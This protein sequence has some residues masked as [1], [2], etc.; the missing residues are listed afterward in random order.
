MKRNVFIR[1]NYFVFI[2]GLIFLNTACKK[3][4][5]STPPDVRITSIS[6]TKGSYGITDTL[7]GIGFGNNIAEVQ[8]FF[9]SVQ[10][11][12]AQIKDN[13][14]IVTV[15]KKA[16]SG[17]I[18][19]VKG[20]QKISG[21]P[22]QYINTITVT[23]LVGKGFP[24]YV[25]GKT[26]DA[27]FNF[28]RGIAM[29]AQGNIFV[30]D[31][32]NYCIRKISVDGNVTTIA[33]N[34]KKGYVDGPAANASFAALNGLA[35]GHDGN[36]YIA[37]ATRIRK[38]SPN[39]NVITTVAGNAN[40]GNTDGDGINATFGLPYSITTDNIG[41]LYAT[42]VAN[43]NVRKIS[44]SAHVSTL[45]GSVQGFADGNGIN[46][47]FNF[48]GAII[49]DS[50]NA[51]MYVAD[52][53]NFRVR[54]LN[55]AGDVFTYAGDGNYGYVDGR[56]FNAEF[57]FPTGI[58]V[59]KKGNVYVCGEDDAVRKISVQGD[60]T[61]IAGSDQEGFLD[62]SGEKAL[63]NQPIYMLTA[64]D[65]TIYVSDH[66]NHAIRKIVIE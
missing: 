18:S 47:L 63:F 20:N 30:A 62:G 19:L 57:K 29:D 50:A 34:S 53:G 52:A 9:G 39:L 43:N 28:P 49:F 37:D 1:G 4:N 13:A 54:T 33:G 40:S 65:G 25:D 59:D 45:A 31:F 48:P 12:I 3:N 11:V 58:T 56:F 44:K 38:W 8:V 14:I 2:T 7:H 24:G 27:L 17:Y 23:T 21:P 66:S 41:N 16:E 26:A 55:A 5:N 51:I 6:P 61:T 15:P 42:D 32:G 22:F 60:V 10:A 36:L 46:A 64:P 35:F